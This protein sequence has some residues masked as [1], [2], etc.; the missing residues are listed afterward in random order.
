LAEVRIYI[1]LLDYSE[2]YHGTPHRPAAALPEGAWSIRY[3]I[4]ATTQQATWAQRIREMPVADAEE[5]LRGLI[6]A[7]KPGSSTGRW[8]NP[9][10]H[11]LWEKALDGAL[12][13]PTPPR[14]AEG[15]E[16]VATGSGRRT[17]SSQ[18]EGRTTRSHSQRGTS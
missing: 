10:A 4:Y 6:R 1:Y 18:P 17:R 12:V 8:P 14:K 16:E 5:L 11:M 15:T 9:P 3:T 7:P 2:L 13:R